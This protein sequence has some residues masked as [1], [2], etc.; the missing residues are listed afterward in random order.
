MCAVADTAVDLVADDYR[1]LRTIREQEVRR[2]AGGR[3]VASE[4]DSD[5]RV[6]SRSM[7]RLLAAGHVAVD[8]EDRVGLTASGRAELDAY[9]MARLRHPTAYA[10]RRPSQQ[11][12]GTDG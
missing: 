1:T 5:R 12:G 10:L 4:G 11:C 8:A 7:E 6:S 9:I 3:Y 2:T